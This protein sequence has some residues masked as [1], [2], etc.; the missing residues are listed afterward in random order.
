[1]RHDSYAWRVFIDEYMVR[2]GMGA[3]VE[4]MRWVAIGY[5]YRFDTRDDGVL[6]PW[7]QRGIKEAV[8]DEFGWPRLESSMSQ[9][10]P[11]RFR[12]T[13]DFAEDCSFFVFG[14]EVGDVVGRGGQAGDLGL[15]QRGW[16]IG[17]V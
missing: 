6:Q 15:M 5:G 16:E 14:D 7:W 12:R 8:L 1:M 13:G 9:V 3:F 11:S 10:L 4:Q 17:H 2:S